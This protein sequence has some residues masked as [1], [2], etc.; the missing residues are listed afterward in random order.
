LTRPDNVAVVSARTWYEDQRVRTILGEGE[1]LEL[2]VVSGRGP[3][4]T[5]VLFEREASR[6]WCVVPRGSVKAKAIAKHPRIAGLVRAGDRSVMLGGRSHIVDPLTARGVAAPERLLVLPRAV[7][8]YLSRN[9][10]DAG[11]VAR[12]RPTP[13]LPLSRV[14]VAIDVTHAAVVDGPEL[15]ATWGGWEPVKLLMHDNPPDPCPPELTT[16]PARLGRLLS[17]ETDVAL[18]WS[19]LSGPS[20]LPGRWKDGTVEVSPDVME[21]TA[22]RMSGPACI[23]FSRSGPKLNDKYGL[24]L[25]GRGSACLRDG[26]A[27]ATIDCDRVTWW[28]GDTIQTIRTTDRR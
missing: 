7:S 20:T 27:V 6:L 22:A 21:L 19:T 13:T 5:P 18:G 23:T 11:G 8:G 2:T 28:R 17:T 24:V 16:L 12:G 4:V 1:V 3:R 26:M 9:L 10:R 25:A 14:I 15:V